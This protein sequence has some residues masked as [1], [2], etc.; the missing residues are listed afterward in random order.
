MAL[1]PCESMPAEHLTPPLQWQATTRRLQLTYV[2]GLAALV[3][4]SRQSGWVGMATGG[5]WL[6]SLFA[7]TGIVV[8][9]VALARAIQVLRRKACLDA[10]VAPG[11]ILWCR[12]IGLAL[13]NVGIASAM[14]QLLMPL[15]VRAVVTRQSG[16]G[17][18]LFVAGIGLAAFGG[19]APCGMLLFEVSRTLGFERWHLTREE[20]TE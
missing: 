8:L 15:I 17:I 20:A 19:F 18:E 11:L 2:L 6:V 5:S 16:S 3:I 4:T 14:L 13:I 1:A 10:P 12:R 9:V 7:F